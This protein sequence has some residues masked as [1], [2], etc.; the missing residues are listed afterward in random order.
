MSKLIIN[1]TISNKK[2]EVRKFFK[3]VRDVNYVNKK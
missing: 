2:C 1:Y 3:F